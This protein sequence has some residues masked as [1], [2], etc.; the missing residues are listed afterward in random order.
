MVIILKNYDRNDENYVYYYVGKNIR[1]YRR[2]RGWTQEKLAEKANYSKQFIS[3]IENDT[4]QTFSLGT[5]WKIAL[6]LEVGIDQLVKEEQSINNRE[7]V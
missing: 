4:H 7:H 6:T 3:N 5:L 2:M 1:K